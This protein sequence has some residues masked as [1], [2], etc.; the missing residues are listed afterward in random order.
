MPLW[1]PSAGLYRQL[2]TCPDFAL[3]QPQPREIGASFEQ[4]GLPL[5]HRSSMT[6]L[7]HIIPQKAKL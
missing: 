1:M 6:T 7:T 5:L 3:I 2:F 4:F